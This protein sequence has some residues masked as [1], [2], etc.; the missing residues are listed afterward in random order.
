[1]FSFS[2]SFF[3]RQG[4]TTCHRLVLNTLCSPGWPGMHYPLGSPHEC[5]NYRYA[6]HVC[7]VSLPSFL[8]CFMEKAGY[9][10]Y[11]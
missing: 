6:Q 4:F 2:F 5:W 11:T 9:K 3:L 10:C 8:S 7:E 1:V